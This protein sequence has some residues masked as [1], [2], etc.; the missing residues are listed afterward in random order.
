[1]LG[2]KHIT[3]LAI[4]DNQLRIA[5]VAVQKNRLQLLKAET[6]QLPKAMET[7]RA[8]EQAKQESS[9]EEESSDELFGFGEEEDEEGESIDLDAELAGEGAEEEQEAGEE[10][11]EFDLA[12]EGGEEDAFESESNAEVLQTVFSGLDGRRP[13][14]ALNIPYGQVLLQI[15][16][17]H[18]YSKMKKKEFDDLVGEKLYSVYNQQL[19][20]D[21][22]RYALREDGSLLLC[23]FE[24]GHP[25]VE[26]IDQA[27]EGDS[28]K[29]YIEDIQSDEAVLI[30]MVRANY[31]L[32]DEEYT[33]IVHIG[34]QS[35]RMI[36]LEGGRIYSIL[37][38]IKE[39]NR[40][41][42]IHSTL[43]SKML[44][45]I[46]RGEVPGIDR[47]IVSD[48]S[49]N[50]DKAC[51]YFHNQFADLEIEKISFDTEKL[52]LPETDEEHPVDYS[53]YALPIG[54]AWVASGMDREKFPGL[55][56][57]PGWIMERQ[58][59]FKLKWHGLLLLMMIAAVPFVFNM[60][61][62]SGVQQ[63]EELESELDQLNRDIADTRP[64]ARI[65]E[66]LADERERIAAGVNLLEQ[67]SDNAVKWTTS[68]SILNE[69]LNDIPNLWVT[70]MNSSG[71]GMDL[72]GYS[73]YRDRITRLAD[74]FH[75]A[76][77]SDVREGEMRGATVYRFTLN[78]EQ[79]VE[80]PEERFRPAPPEFPEEMLEE[81][82]EL[83]DFA[84]S[85]AR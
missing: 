44:F 24:G 45:E 59:V 47:I 82:Q 49:G 74:V 71:E 33:A 12:E 29:V 54:L 80:N 58:Q 5:Q 48:P 15:L 40:S 75:H 66:N 83:F 22:Y 8:L 65:T 21:N 60:Y 84:G 11:D 78:V 28:S 70:N 73:L 35:S 9:S 85:V 34:S 55:S 52:E 38:L 72:Q 39:G 56:F 53:T 64:V 27:L 6:L 51:E 68:L 17:D 23:S 31:H 1:M 19:S 7:A 62:Q 2:E 30:G 57:L 16:T 69:A 42:N 67:V 63:I 20:K 77:V 4:E 25:L 43:F 37:P 3:G 76:T 50:G 14:V 32:A 46:D 36:F 41:R 61:Y 26:T 81:Q 13:S 79:I 18:D 10:G